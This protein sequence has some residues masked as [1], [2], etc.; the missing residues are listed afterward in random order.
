MFMRL[1]FTRLFAA[2][3]LTAAV[4]CHTIA[5]AATNPPAFIEKLTYSAL[6]TLGDQA[7]GEKER[8]SKFHALL[9][10]NVDMPRVGRFVLGA[11]WRKADTAQ[12]AEFQKL[13]KDYL[14]SAYAGRLKDYT[15]AKIRIKNTTGVGKN[16]YLVSSQVTNP[17][18]PEP[19]SVDWRLRESEDK[20]LVLDMTIEGI[21]MALT[22][23]SEFAS[24]I[25][26]NGGDINA[27]LAR[28]RSSAG[29]VS[30]GEQISIAN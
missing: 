18:N 28:M 25:Q 9:S 3:L 5:I 12:Q 27:L 17:N 15:R 11:N 19:V 20:L 26:K 22:Q 13:Y 21:S 8:Y 30:D 29:A 2:T 16:E 6:E 23:R 4:L 10:D 1:N 7:I 14:I 24:I